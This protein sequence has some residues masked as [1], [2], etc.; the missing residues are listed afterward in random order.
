MY[1]TDICEAMELI[2]EPYNTVEFLYFIKTE[3]FDPKVFFS[4]VRN[5]KPNQLIYRWIHDT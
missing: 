4:S 1:P 2:I 3:R 5:I